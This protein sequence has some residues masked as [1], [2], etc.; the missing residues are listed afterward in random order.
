MLLLTRMFK[1]IFMGENVTGHVIPEERTPARKRSAKL[2]WNITK[3]AKKAMGGW[4]KDV[5]RRVIRLVHW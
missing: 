1:N 2:V 5:S 3:Y 4:G